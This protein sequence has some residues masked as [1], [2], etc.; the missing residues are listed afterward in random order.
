MTATTAF[1]PDQAASPTPPV[2][3]WS[4]FLFLWGTWQAAL[5]NGNWSQ[6]TT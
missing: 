1:T 5:T 6:A 2:R 3:L 4:N